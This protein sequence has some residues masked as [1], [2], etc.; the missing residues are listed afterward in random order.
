VTGAEGGINYY[1]DGEAVI[2]HF[3]VQAAD[4]GVRAGQ[5]DP[6]KE[7]NVN[8]K[9][10]LTIESSD[11]TANYPIWLRGDAPAT[12]E[13]RQT[14]LRAIEGGTD[15]RDDTKKDDASQVT[16]YRS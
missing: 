15:I 7:L 2:S 12:V 4:Y 3:K 6:N 10:K 13:I 5:N 9:A 8:T 11:I 16:I 1:G 14:E